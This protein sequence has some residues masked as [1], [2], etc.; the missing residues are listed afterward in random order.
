MNI[1]SC[2]RC[3]EEKSIYDFYFYKTTNKHSSECK[4]CKKQLNH[5]YN[6]MKKK[7]KE[8]SAIRVYTCSTCGETMTLD[9]FYIS[10]KTGKPYS[11]CKSCRCKLKA[12][13]YQ[14]KKLKNTTKIC[15]CCGEDK[16]IDQ[17][18]YSKTRKL[19]YA[20]CKSCHKIYTERS[21][22]KRMIKDNTIK[23]ES[24][25]KLNIA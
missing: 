11:I 10:S 3:G 18:Y 15:T 5:R 16:P 21:K 1:K 25:L 2:S 12:K 4:A 14:K 6:E 24:Q 20:H 17:F 23:T 9:Q 8:M 7:E 22:L 19:Y 13:S